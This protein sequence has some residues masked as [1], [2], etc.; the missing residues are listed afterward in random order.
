[1][2]R[3]KALVNGDSTYARPGNWIAPPDSKPSGFGA[4]KQLKLLVERGAKAMKRTSLTDRLP[5]LFRS[6]HRTQHGRDGNCT[7]R[8]SHARERKGATVDRSAGA[9][10]PVHR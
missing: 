4:M 9:G 6:T 8:R 1:M 5:V 7:G 2:R 3:E 10:K